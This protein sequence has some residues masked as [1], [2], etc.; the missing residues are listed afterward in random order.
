MATSGRGSGRRS[1]REPRDD[2]HAPV[3]ITAA[4]KPYEQEL[5]DRKRRYFFLMSLRI[6]AL[7]LAVIA[8]LIWENGWISMAIVGFSIPIPW[9]AVLGAND[10]PARSKHEPRGYSRGSLADSFV[11]R[12]LGPGGVV[13]PTG[14]A[15]GPGDP[16]DAGNPGD[17]SE[18]DGRTGSGERRDDGIIDGDRF[19]PPFSPPR[20]SGPRSRRSSKGR[21][22]GSAG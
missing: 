20:E 21:D 14:D 18:G 5:A 17:A 7:V 6:P 13:Y 9:I 2:T 12:Q 22:P 1:G 8:Y 19:S 16:G 3:L 4:R 15:G 11:T 10:R